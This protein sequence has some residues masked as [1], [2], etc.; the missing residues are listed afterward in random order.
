MKTVR[1]HQ[2]KRKRVHQ[3]LEKY[4]HPNPRIRFLDNI[5][6][7]VAVIIPFMVIPQIYN[8]WVLRIVDGVSLITWTMFF[9][10]TF[11]LLIYSIVHKAKPLITMYILW[12]VFH[13]ITISGILLFG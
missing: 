13:S 10:L 4:P 8:I 2:H 12:L 11:P 9:I 1:I 6:S 5:V 7:V 3:R